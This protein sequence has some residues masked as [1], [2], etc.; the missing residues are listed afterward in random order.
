[1]TGHLR[2]SDCLGQGLWLLVLLVCAT[3]Q[4]GPPRRLPLVAN[5]QALPDQPEARAVAP[6]PEAPQQMVLYFYSGGEKVFLVDTELAFV[7]LKDQVTPRD[8]QTQQL[9][10]SPRNPL[11]EVQQSYQAQQGL[12]LVETRGPGLVPLVQN[13]D[14]VEYVLP[15]VEAVRR[16]GP[17]DA[18]QP[19]DA[20]DGASRPLPLVMTKTI[21]ARFQQGTNVPEYVNGFGLKVVKKRRGNV[22]ELG[23]KE[24]FDYTKLIYAA[25][26]LYVQ[27]T[28]QG[29]VKYSHPN[30]KPIPTRQQPV[31]VPRLQ[32]TSDARDTGAGET[33]A[34]DTGA[35]DTSAEDTSAEDTGAED[36]GAEDTGAE[37]TSAEDTGAGE[38]GAEDSQTDDS[39]GDQSEEDATEQQTGMGEPDPAQEPRFGN[40]WH[41]RNTRDHAGV[42]DADVDAELA[43]GITRG[44]REIRI[45]IID[46]SVEKDHPD[47]KANFQAGIYYGPDGQEDPDPSPRTGD[48]WHGTPCAGVAVGAADGQGITGLAPKCGLIGIHFWDASLAQTAD[49]FRFAADPDDDPTTDDGA[50]VIS[51]SWS[52]DTAFDS[53]RDAVEE[54]AETGFQ[55]KG[56]VVLFAS[57]NNYGTIARNQRFALLDSVLIVG[58]SNWR[59]DHPRYSNRGP[60]LDVVA[61]SHDE[62]VAEAKSIDTADNTEDSPRFR[63]RSFSGL[64]LGPYTGNGSTG[65]GGTSSATPLVAGLCGLIRSANPELTASQVRSIV[66]HCVDRIRGDRKP[67]NYH[68]TTGHDENYGYGRV[69]AFQAV[70]VASA[71]R[72]NPGIIWPEQVTN[73][74]V[75]RVVQGECQ[76]PI[77][78]MILQWTHLDE[79]SV[80][81]VL[82]VRS[83]GPV[84]WRPHDGTRFQVGDRLA[85]GQATVVS[86]AKGTSLTDSSQPPGTVYAVIP[87][88]DD[89]HYGWAQ[90][91]SVS[92]Q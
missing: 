57:G 8:V 10:L 19:D 75:E 77:E 15:V 4:A 41:L 23:L 58:A 69:N 24:A 61:P 36:T 59:D 66:R 54:V 65:F 47:L 84:A 44:L 12:A 55:G 14:Q 38:T 56:V 6:S 25:N 27:G 72:L 49:A 16:N 81:G 39:E 70:T 34:S 20:A 28:Q 79:Q 17:D 88:S 67:A 83:P 1:M 5:P 74:K 91:V 26:L 32:D 68:P 53:V 60:E 11:R 33:D 7:K 52:W 50:A 31:A 48:H 51:C 9:T 37:D 73:L 29:K 45:A 71:A 87:Y 80:A 43:W 40:Q 30:F 76:E 42:P 46:D 35:E 82:V 63:G 90:I 85:D 62:D 92:D 89:Y 2:I 78:Q 3:S 18:D 13:T 86:V 64:T 22:Y 21:V